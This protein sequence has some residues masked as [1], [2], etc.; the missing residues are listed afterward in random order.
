VTPLA[1]RID[2]AR[3]V[4]RARFGFRDFRPGQLRAVRAALAGRSAL[5]VLPTGGGK[6]LCYQIPALVLDG[7]TVVVS[8]LISLMQDQVDAARAR[9]IWAASLTS[10][11][12]PADRARTLADAERGGLKLL[13]LAPE[14]LM[15]GEIIG[16]L[17]RIRPCL[18]AVD[19]AHCVSEWG[20]DF[21]PAYRKIGLARLALGKPPTLALTATATRAVRDDVVASLR[22][23]PIERIVGSFDRPNLFFA[24][25]RVRDEEERRHELLGL[26]RPY[27]GPSIVYV[28]TRRLAE[29]WSRSLLNAG[30]DAV[31]YHA[32]LEHMVRRALQDRFTADRIECVVATTAFGLGIDKANVRR[33]V[34]LGLATSLEAYYQEAGRAGRDGKRARCE[35]LWTQGDV[36]LQ[37]M[38]LQDDRKLDPLLRYLTAFG[39]RRAELLRHFDERVGHCGGCDRCEK[40]MRWFGRGEARHPASAAAVEE[41]DGLAGLAGVAGGPRG[42]LAPV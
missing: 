2:Q 6:S 32:G 34:H 42:H 31:P 7:L 17:R 25:R 23:G 39:C 1:V 37:R 14:R 26:L 19:E 20:Q 4:L 11:S 27:R 33:V 9:G 5:V 15:T 10:A 22:L 29:R 24:A 21:R 30:V 41:A 16:A 12:G 36:R 18:L 38:I 3:D 40:W 28:P 8:P 13:Y 35:V